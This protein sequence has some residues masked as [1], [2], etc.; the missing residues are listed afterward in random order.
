[1]KE[2]DELQFDKLSPRL[3]K[4]IR[5]VMQ[6]LYND[7][8]HLNKSDL[9]ISMGFSAADTLWLIG[10]AIECEMLE[11]SNSDQSKGGSE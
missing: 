6:A 4:M 3:Q 11:L 1:M 2:F 7:S 10:A 9:S 5:Y 8:K